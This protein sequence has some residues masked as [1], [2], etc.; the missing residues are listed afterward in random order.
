LSDGKFY[1][2]GVELRDKGRG[3]VTDKAEDVG[4]FRTPGLRNV[5]NTGPYMH[6]GSL[7]TLDD[8]V[9]F[10]YRGVPQGQGGMALDVEPLL[11]QSF[12]E[13]PAIVAFLE[14]LSGEAPKIT[15]PELP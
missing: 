14:S 8:V 3:A 13:I 1:R 10:Y 4:K 12:S 6:D 2:I 15:P 11:G 7:K 5:A 9:T